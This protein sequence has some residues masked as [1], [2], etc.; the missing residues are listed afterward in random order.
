[1]ASGSV[2]EAPAVVAGLED[3][4]VMSEPVEECRGHLGIAEDGWPFA[5]CEVGGDDDRGAFVETAYEMEEQLS[6]S[7]GEGQI[8]ILK[9]SFDH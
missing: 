2:L 1:M 9:S 4:A 5:E 3:L 8:V 6:A 7:L